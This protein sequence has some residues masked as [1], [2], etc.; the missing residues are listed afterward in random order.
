MT[1]KSRVH[2]SFV[3]PYVQQEVT[4]HASGAAADKAQKSLADSARKKRSTALTKA[5]PAAG[6]RADPG[7]RPDRHRPTRGLRLRPT[8]TSG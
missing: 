8:T 5:A 1:A 4:K 2:C 6:G 3:P 7:P